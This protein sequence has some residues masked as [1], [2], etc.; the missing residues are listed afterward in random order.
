M[1]RL[2]KQAGFTLIE[3]VVVIVILGILAVTAA[4]KFLDLSSDANTATLNAI[5]ASMQSA[6]TI[7]HSKSLIAGNQ[8]TDTATVTVNGASLDIAYGYPRS[9]DKA[10]WDALLEFDTDDF[11]SVLVD[12]DTVIIYPTGMAA[13]DAITDACIVYYQEVTAAGN[14]PTIEVVDCS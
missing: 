3:L 6:S 13:P 8:D 12:S 11:T 14:T 7:V 2:Q 4:P 9:D 1:K 10:D 5:K